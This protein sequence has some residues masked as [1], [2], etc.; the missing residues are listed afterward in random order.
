MPFLPHLLRSCILK[1]SRYL[2][3]TMLISV[4]PYHS[5]SWRKLLACWIDT[6]GGNL[7]FVFKKTQLLHLLWVCQESYW[8]SL[9]F[10]CLSLK[11]SDK[12]HFAGYFYWGERATKWGHFCQILNMVALVPLLTTI[13]SLNWEVLQYSGYNDQL[14]DWITTYG[15][16]G[17]LH[18]V[19]IPFLLMCKWE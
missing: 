7:C 17:K 3:L 16:L 5:P 9:S 18:N 1:N 8:T 4:F 19:F 10:S 2:T 12:F 15:N 6:N 14:Q 13:P 11:L